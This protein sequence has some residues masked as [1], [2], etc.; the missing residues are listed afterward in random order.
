M[1]IM[2]ALMIDSNGDRDG[3]QHFTGYAISK[4]E[5]PLSISTA[6]V[7]N[8][9]SLNRNDQHRLL[10]LDAWSSGSGAT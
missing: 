9:S 8:N 4:P 7:N 6:V 2:I 10:Y 1:S 3:N 5:S